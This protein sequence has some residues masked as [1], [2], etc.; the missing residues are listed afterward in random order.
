MP[1]PDR[2]RSR[3]SPRSTARSRTSSTCASPRTA[4]RSSTIARRTTR[5]GG[6]RWTSCGNRAKVRAWRER[7]RAPPGERRRARV[8]APSARAA[9]RSTCGDAQLA[10][11]RRSAADALVAGLPLARAHAPRPRGPAADGCGST[12]GATV[13]HA[14]TVLGPALSAGRSTRSPAAPAR[15][16]SR[17]TSPRSTRWRPTTPT[18][19]GPRRAPAGWCRAPTVFE[20]V[21]KTV[22]T[23]NCTWS[24]DP[25]DGARA[26]PRT[27]ASRRSAPAA[28]PLGRAFP[29]PERDGRGRRGASTATSLAAGYRGA[30]LIATR[31]ARSPRASSTCER[32]RRRLDRRSSRTRIWSA[33]LALPGVGPYAAAHS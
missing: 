6:A 22:C 8:P 3:S 10:R 32:S 7:Q 12:P 5:A 4:A 33:L 14:L 30:Y 11:V 26:R 18:C 13:T 20:D 19:P 27:S 24:A 23:T 9:S 28:G 1:R 21:V 2:W 16:S 29:T 17:P 25:P 31:R 15:P